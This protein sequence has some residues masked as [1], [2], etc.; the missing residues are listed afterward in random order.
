MNEIWLYVANDGGVRVADKLI[1]KLI[2]CFIA[3]AKMPRAGRLQ[4]EFASGIRR[5]PVANYYIYYREKRNGGVLI[6]RV[7]HAKRDQ[8]KAF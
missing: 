4:P 1:D 3:L 8:Q 7:I 5:F 6:V 2:D